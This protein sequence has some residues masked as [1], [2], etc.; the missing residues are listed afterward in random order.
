MPP[1]STGETKVLLLML[2][3]KDLVDHAGLSLLQVQWKEHITLPLEH[4]SPFQN[5]NLL[6]AQEVMETKVAMVDSM[7]MLS[8][9]P[10]VILL[11]L[12]MNI[13]ILLMM[14]DAMPTQEPLG[15]MITKIYTPTI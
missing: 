5:N 11:K 2:R 4:Y 1:L 15:L 6:T 7:T 12:R 8:T 10:I 14:E 3:I 9:M 13:H